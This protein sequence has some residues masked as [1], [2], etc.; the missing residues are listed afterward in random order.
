[1]YS[2]DMVKAVKYMETAIDTDNS[3][4]QAY[5]TLATIEM[6]RWLM[7]RNGYSSVNGL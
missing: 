4:V 3:C 7:F 2:Q 6:Q 1:M 5:N